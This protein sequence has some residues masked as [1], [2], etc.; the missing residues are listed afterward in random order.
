VNLNDA[1]ARAWDDGYIEGSAQM[2]LYV[3]ANATIGNPYKK[4]ELTAQDALDVA[5]ALLAPVEDHAVE[6][7]AHDW[8]AH[9]I[10]HDRCRQCGNLRDTR[11]D[12]AHDP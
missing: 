5:A 1:L 7:H 4:T 8:A 9:Q 12:H 11:A 10:H 2:G 3:S 6:G